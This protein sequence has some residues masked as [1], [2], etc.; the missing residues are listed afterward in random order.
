M[1]KLTDQ[2][3]KCLR[4]IDAMIGLDEDS[5]AFDTAEL[6]SAGL[7]LMGEHRLI[8]LSDLGYQ[9]LA[10]YDA[11]WVMVERAHLANIVEIADITNEHFYEELQQLTTEAHALRQ[12]DLDDATVEKLRQL[13]GLIAG[14]AKEYTAAYEAIQHVNAALAGEQPKPEPPAEWVC[15]DN[16]WRRGHSTGELLLF[17]NKYRV[18]ADGLIERLGSSWSQVEIDQARAVLWPELQEAAK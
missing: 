6:F 8:D 12:T 10:A 5:C 17:Q 14:N 9:A 16:L 3:A 15:G 13:E 1:G 2:Q 4:A 11:E 18:S 7:V